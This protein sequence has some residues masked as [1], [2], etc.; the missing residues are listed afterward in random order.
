MD[1]QRP[2]MP[3][4]PWQAYRNLPDEDLK[5]IW[6]YLQSLPPIKNA[7]PVYMPPVQSKM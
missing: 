4:M 2:I 5:A 6:A 1:Q 7:V 3:P